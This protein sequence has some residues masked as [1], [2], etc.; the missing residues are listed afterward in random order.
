MTDQ[1]LRKQ[2]SKGKVIFREGEPADCAYILKKGSVELACLK[3]GHVHPIARIKEGDIFGEMALMD[4]SVRIATA[5]ALEDIEVL[6]VS[7]E[8]IESKIETTDSIVRLLLQVTLERYRDIHAR[9]FSVVENLTTSSQSTYE[10]TTTLTGTRMMGR[11]VQ[12]Y[13]GLSDKIRN[14]IRASH[15]QIDTNG[16]SYRGEVESTSDDLIKERRLEEA[17]K[18]NEFEL[19]YQPIVN[20][21]TGKITACESLV[22]WIDPVKGVVPP[23]EFIPLAE[24]TGLINPLGSWILN[25]ASMAA[26]KFRETKSVC[27]SINMSGMQLE[28]PEFVTEF[29]QMLVSGNHNP[30]DI[31]LEITETLL[32]SNPELAAS[33]LKDIKNLGVKIAIDDFGTGYSSFSY[34][35]RFPID[36]LKV[37]RSFVMSMLNNQKSLE[38]VSSLVGLAHNL[39][40]SVIAEGIE[41]EAEL[42][43]LTELNCEYGQGYHFSRPVPFAEFQKLL[44][45]ETSA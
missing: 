2:F 33:K 20:L 45:A 23:D 44:A 34:L 41:T 9:L 32:M 30:Q 14:A 16:V 27:M 39:G 4:N 12:Q 35:H 26:T 36:T 6:P 25:E 15:N 37:D 29:E 17:L 13:Q 24:K 22:R 18:N 11:M 42:E 19:Y 43:K 10:E 1:E 21:E 3:L 38:I 28:Q 5:T 8:Y 7:R 31:K 40:M